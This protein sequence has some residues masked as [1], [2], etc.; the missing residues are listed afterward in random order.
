MTNL[1]PSTFWVLMLAATAS[2]QARATSEDDAR[3]EQEVRARFD[4][5]NQAWKNRD[6]SFIR[7]FYAH[8]ENML[9]FFERRQLR[10]W[11]KVERLYE[12]MFAHAL[13]G[14]VNSTYSNLEIQARGDLAYVAANFHLEVQNPQG[15]T[16]TDTGRVSVVFQRRD[17]KWLVVHRHT[18]FQAPPGPQR[19]VPLHTEPGP[20][21][22]PS[23]EGAWRTDGGA[24]LLATATYLSS[25]GV[26]GLPQ[27]ATYRV[28]DEGIWLTEEGKA[29]R[30]V[31]LTRLTSTE[32]MLRLPGGAYA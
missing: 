3:A 15:E 5:F 14:S 29:A 7:D 10:G 18:S 17:D 11:D 1:F 16:M 13:P 8:D 12:N 19:K 2:A 30:L 26:G 23:L 20:L 27:T 32:L 6:M 28:A 31:E 21:W 4:A 25:R 9:L 22:S 24:L